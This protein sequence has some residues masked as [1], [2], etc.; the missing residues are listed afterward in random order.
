MFCFQRYI[1][2]V[3]NCRCHGFGSKDAVCCKYPVSREGC[4]NIYST[5]DFS[6]SN[7][8]S[9]LIYQWCWCW[10]VR[11]KLLIVYGVIYKQVCMLDLQIIMKRW[12]VFFLSREYSPM[13]GDSGLA[14]STM[15]HDTKVYFIKIDECLLHNRNLSTHWIKISLKS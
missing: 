2:N 9:I 14:H 11:H 8:S 10:H 7:G 15:I 1:H 6:H 3:C 4:L 12:Q 13:E 5:W